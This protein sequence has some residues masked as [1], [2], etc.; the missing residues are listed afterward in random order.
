MYDEILDQ[1]K[2]PFSNSFISKSA[3]SALVSVSSYLRVNKANKSSLILFAWRSR[4]ALLLQP[5]LRIGAL[6]TVVRTVCI[7]LFL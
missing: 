6:N 2:F 7:L 3:S 4:L 5:D 1:S